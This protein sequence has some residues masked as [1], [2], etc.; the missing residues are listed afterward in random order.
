MTERE[1]AAPAW[2]GRYDTKDHPLDPPS[3]PALSRPTTDGRRPP[4]EGVDALELTR[5][6][7]VLGLLALALVLFIGLMLVLRLTV[8]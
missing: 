3:A 6:F 7:A 8:L 1:R 4:G 2:Q 5:L